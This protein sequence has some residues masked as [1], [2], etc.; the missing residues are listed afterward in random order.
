MA[1]SDFI[2]QKV[3]TFG[4][5]N[6]AP[7]LSGD[8]IVR[9]YRGGQAAAMAEYQR[10]AQAMASQGYYPTSQVWAPGSWGCGAFLVALL[11]CLLLVGILVFIYMVVVKPA[12]TLTVTYQRR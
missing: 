4:E 8:V 5:S 9:I 12:G 3:A 1:G 7:P 11:L 10:E 6:A 2:S